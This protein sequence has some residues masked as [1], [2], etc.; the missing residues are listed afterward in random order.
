MSQYYHQ[1]LQIQ[2]K[3]GIEVAKKIGYP[4][5]LRPA[6]TL[7]VTGGGF[8]DDEKELK[9]LIK[10]ALTLSPTHQVLIEKSIKGYKE[11]EYEV[12]RDK[13][14]SAITVCNME[15]LRS[16]RNSY[17]RFNRCMSFTNIN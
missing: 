9:S 6:F 2:L 14:D 8:A 4:V 15:K 11:I 5:V 1:R 16:S 10:H 12:I 13:N 17:R 7:G 3:E